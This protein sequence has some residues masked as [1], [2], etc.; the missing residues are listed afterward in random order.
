VFLAEADIRARIA[1]G[2]LRI[3][4]SLD[5]RHLSSFAID[6]RLG[7]QFL[8]LPFAGTAG[9]IIDP[10]RAQ[11]LVPE[12]RS[13]QTVALG[14]RLELAPGAAVL[15]VS[16]EYVYLPSDLA[17]FL[18]PRSSLERLGLVLGAGS[19]DPGYQ[20]KLTFLMRNNNTVSIVLRPGQPIIRLCL[21]QLSRPSRPL[22]ARP[23]LAKPSLGIL[24]D[25]VALQTLKSTVDRYA[26]RGAVDAT[27]DSTFSARLAV[28]LA[29][30]GAAKGKLL[31]QLMAD[32]FGAVDGLRIMK[33]NARVRAEELDLVIK[34]HIETGFWRIAGSPIIVECK[35]WAAKVGAREITLL[36]E[37]LQALSPDAKTGILV[38]L[39]G[40]TG[41]S[42]K[43]AVLKIREARQRGRYILVFDRHDLK[44]IAGGTSL[45]QMIEKKYDATILI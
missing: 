32:M 9:I 28:L 39:N 40:I 17:G 19:I 43:D 13:L 3:D 41:N 12:A 27:P 10:A 26:G 36:L 33:R 2:G 44:E 18:F 23:A 21:A 8:N 34:S 1:N 35:N 5:D 45:D 11:D 37:K 14:D 15:G 20:G 16:L 7:T 38:A 30:K 6:L 22:A 25:D 31:E 29:A 4:P 42:Y 24:P